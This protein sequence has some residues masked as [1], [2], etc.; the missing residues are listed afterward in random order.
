MDIPFALLLFCVLA[1]CSL[2]VILIGA[3]VY[4]DTVARADETFF[5]GT[6]LAYLSNKIRQHDAQDAVYLGQVEEV[7]AL[8]LE[9][10]FNQGR[11]ATYI[12][13]HDGSLREVMARVGEEVLLTDGQEILPV[14]RFEAVWE[15]EG[16][17]RLTVRERGVESSLLVA[18]RCGES[19][20][21]GGSS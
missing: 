8:V 3:G 5:S 18:L 20:G 21:T 10:D 13:H 14:G 6:S 12:F 7:S 15:E 17:L 2:A 19:N 4:R 11:F 1:A 16:L 9:Q